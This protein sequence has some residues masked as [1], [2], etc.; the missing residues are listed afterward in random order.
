MPSLVQN[1]PSDSE[2]S[3]LGNK[4]NEDDESKDDAAND[5]ISDDQ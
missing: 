2:T 1:T 3:Q 4:I 5:G